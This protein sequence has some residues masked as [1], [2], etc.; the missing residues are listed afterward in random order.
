VSEE[1]ITHIALFLAGVSIGMTI[2][3]LINVAK[4]VQS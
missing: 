3:N 1:R 2:I 4:G